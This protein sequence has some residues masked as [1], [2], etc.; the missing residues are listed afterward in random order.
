MIRK[1]ISKLNYDY[2]E[3]NTNNLENWL[4]SFSLNLINSEIKPIEGMD[5][6]NREYNKTIHTNGDF[7][8]TA[9]RKIFIVFKDSDLFQEKKNAIEKFFAPASTEKLSFT[10]TAYN[11]LAKSIS[12]MSLNE[13]RLL[14]TEQNLKQT[15]DAYVKSENELNEIKNSRSY[16]Y[17]RR[18]QR[19][20]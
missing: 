8:G 20:K 6:L 14:L 16:R 7:S 9:Y 11:L 15:Q 10:M 4:I 13:D 18:I 1:T 5:A 3:L 12:K 2:I 17:M 19:K